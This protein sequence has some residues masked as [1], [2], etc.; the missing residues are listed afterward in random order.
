MVDTNFLVDVEAERPGALATLDRIVVREEDLRVP[1]AVWVEFLAGANPGRRSGL[2]QALQAGTY[3]HPFGEA[4]AREAV[5]LH[6]ELMDLGR[7]L[8]WHDL[9][10]AATARLLGEPLVSNDQAFRH[11]PRLEVKPF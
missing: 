8:K 2:E 1:A 6:R 9:Q 7:P 11:V 4:E 10:V 3:L 5:A